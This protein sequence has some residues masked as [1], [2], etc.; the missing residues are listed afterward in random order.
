MQPDIS[1]D[2]LVPLL[3]LISLSISDSVRDIDLTQ[4][5]PVNWGPSGRGTM[6]MPDLGVIGYLHLLNNLLLFFT[7]LVV[8]EEF[9]NSAVK[10][11]LDSG[12]PLTNVALVI[13]V[14]IIWILTPL[15]EFKE[16][17]QITTS[18]FG[19]PKS[20]FLYAC[21]IFTVVM[22]LTI[23]DRIE[24]LIPLYIEVALVILALLLMIGGNILYLGKLNEE[25]LE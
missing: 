8:L 1:V 9:D 12:V 3:A 5:E 24:A 21:D 23:T 13:V 4:A 16:Y 2:L 6:L 20:I 10:V 25:V 22:I 17:V 18:S 11:I 15:L 14:A 7:Y 19:Y